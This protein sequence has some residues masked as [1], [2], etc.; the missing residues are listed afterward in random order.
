MNR[1][2]SGA[3]VALLTLTLVACGGRP[4]AEPTAEPTTPPATE[5]PAPTPTATSLPAP[6]TVLE[7][8]MAAGNFQALLDAISAADLAE[9]LSSEGPYTVLAPT[10]FAFSEVDP[11]ILEDPEALA[12][13]LMYHIIEGDLSAAALGEAQSATSLLGDTLTFTTEDDQILVNGAPIA[14]ADIE[15]DNGV[16]HVLQEVLLPPSLAD[17]APAEADTESASVGETAAGAV[18]AASAAVAGAAEA[19]QSAVEETVANADVDAAAVADRAAGA[20]DAVQDAAARRS[21]CR[22]SSGCQR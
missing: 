2:F 1:L 7:I 16:I 6:S 17:M 19:A 13:T 15:A 12:D 4:G 3:L 21:R 14:I 5:T 9:K 10:D 11:S 8:A 20:V 22:P 18:A